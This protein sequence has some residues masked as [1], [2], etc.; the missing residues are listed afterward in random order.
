MPN[1]HFK[2]V[3]THILCVSLVCVSFIFFRTNI[4][5][6]ATLAIGNINS[7]STPSSVV[8]TNVLPI[9]NDAKS[10]GPV[11]FVG[12][13]M[14]A[15]HVEYLISINGNDY[16]YRNLAFLTDEPDSIVIANFEGTVPEVHKKTPNFGFSFS[17]D[18]KNLPNLRTAGFTHFSLA[19]NHS[20]DKGKEALFNTEIKLLNNDLITF[21]R[22]G[23][24]STSSVTLFKRDQQNVAVVAFY[25]L[26][27]LPTKKEIM[28]LL[29][30]LDSKPDY[31][32]AFVHWG[33]EYQ[34]LP[35]IAQKSF[36][37]TLADT[38]FNLVIGHHPHVVQSIETIDNTTI[39]YSLGNF[40][41]DQYFAQSVQTGLA[42]KLNFSTNEVQID[43]LPVT[44]IGSNAQ[45]K[46]MDSIE[47]K[48]F[49]NNLARISS[50]N[51]LEQITSGRITYKKAL[52][53]SS[54]IA[55]MGQ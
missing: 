9:E 31:L 6:P 33:D 15:R 53:T 1:S 36:A 51:Q 17:V 43:L 19:N 32:I 18:E 10:S 23:E 37:R 39:F 47:S 2:I 34:N 49:L 54:E 4:L 41:F 5:Q 8:E 27:N 42:L 55:I 25:T 30:S 11:F 45:P 16:P 46:L 12:D 44:S 26:V 3:I 52:A 7:Y 28:N 13:V 24:I 14:L 38:G 50:K 48:D 35:N 29:T 21:G 20:L 22:P 40:I